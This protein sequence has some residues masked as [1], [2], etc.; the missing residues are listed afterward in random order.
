RDDKLAPLALLDAGLAALDGGNP[1]RAVTHLQAAEKAARAAGQAPVADEAHATLQSFAH[2]S[3]R[4]IAP[5]LQRLTLEGKEALR[6]HRYRDAAADYRR[7][8]DVAVAEGASAADRA[9][10]DYALGNALWRAN[11]LVAAARALTAAVELAPGEAE[12]HYLLGVVHFDAG[13]DRDAKVALERAVALGLPAAEARRAADIL[14]ALKETRRGETSRLF[15]ELRVAGG[16]DTNVPQSGVFVSATHPSAEASTA[17]LLEGDFDFFWRPAGT[18]RNGFSVEYRFGQLAYL[19]NELDVYSLQEHDVALSGAW[20]PTSRLTL[21]LGGDGYVLF[22][23]VE[24]FAP[25]Q[26]GAS[27]GPRIT[28]REPRGFETRLRAQHIFKH[29]LDPTYDYLSGNR[30]E[31]GLAELWHDPKDRLSLGY[32]FAREDIGV[33]KVALG[34]LDLPRA[35]L[36]TFDPNAVYFIPYSYFSHEV[37]LGATR[38]LPRAFLGS[39]ALRYEHRDYDQAAHIAAPNGTPSYYRVRRDDHVAIDVSLRHPI[40]LG[41]DIELAYTLAINHSTID[42]TRASTPLDYDDK[43]YVKQVVQLD[44]GFVY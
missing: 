11:D 6:A 25:F 17:P 21:E 20:T 32:L 35:A 15:V 42:N 39:V 29:S 28:V 24:T 5:E 30:D 4:T 12:F 19:S 8:L 31:A 37:A 18:A 27:V 16:L 2:R 3:T 38:D 34:L 7:A 40:A 26:T 36:G 43:S 22:S 41:F 23:G 13:A 44:F 10:L 9:E 1:E 14:R 33:Q